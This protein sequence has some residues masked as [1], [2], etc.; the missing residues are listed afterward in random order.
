M[1]ARFAC[2]TRPPTFGTLT[3]TQYRIGA[4]TINDT[5][6]AKPFYTRKP[7]PFLVLDDDRL[8][9]A[10][11]ARHDGLCEGCGLAGLAEA[12]GDHRRI[13]SNAHSTATHLFETVS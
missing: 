1:I 9:A 3:E 12:G 13:S 8:R 10:H 2:F 5:E 7:A 6:L 11:D 4:D